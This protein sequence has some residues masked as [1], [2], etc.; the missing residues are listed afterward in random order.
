MTNTNELNK[1]I[2]ESGLRKEKIANE[3]GISLS[4]L[5]NKIAN[6]TSFYVDEIEILKRTLK[7]NEKQFTSIF[8]AQRV[9]SYDTLKG[10]VNG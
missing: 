10:A 6:R 3:L 7:L 1:V 4:S 2:K 8:F 9:S 5:N